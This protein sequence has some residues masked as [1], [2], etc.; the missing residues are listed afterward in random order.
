MNN[1]GYNNLEDMIKVGII[2]EID[3]KKTL[4]RVKFEQDDDVKSYWFQPLFASTNKNKVYHQYS[5][6]EQVLVLMPYEGNQDGYIV[7]SMYSDEDKPPRTNE[8]L[9]YIEFENGDYIQYDK[10]NKS[11][12][13]NAPDCELVLNVKSLKIQADNIE[14]I[15][16][17]LQNTAE[18]ISVMCDDYVANA[19]CAMITGD[20]ISLIASEEIIQNSENHVM[21][22]DD[23]GVLAKTTDIVSDTGI[24]ITAK[25]NINAVA[26]ASFAITSPATTA[27]GT[28]GIT[29]ATTVGGTLGVTGATTLA[30]TLGVTGA[31]TLSDTLA[32][33]KAT[34]L[35]STLGVTG[36]TSLKNTYVNGTGTLNSAVIGGLN[37]AQHSHAHGEPYVSTPV[38]HPLT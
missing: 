29:G 10:T 3:L 6:G 4:Y 26:P 28:M 16:K 13:V 19:D 37:F 20:N 21:Q 33:T 23:Y 30:N 9:Q 12:T 7:G 15:G 11:L 35:S 18:S 25:T 22:Y 1:Y 24:N 5:L 8:G 17:S 38:Q 32:V 2:N 31:A 27:S 14:T 36:E 34:T